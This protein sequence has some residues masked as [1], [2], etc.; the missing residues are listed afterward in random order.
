MSCEKVAAPEAGIAVANARPTRTT[1]ANVAQTRSRGGRCIKYHRA[2]TFR[3]DSGRG[4]TQMASGTFMIRQ[5]GRDTQL[6][7]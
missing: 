5:I 6:R 3:H 2:S 1:R 4:T 7:R